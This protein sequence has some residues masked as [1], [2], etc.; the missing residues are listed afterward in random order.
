MFSGKIKKTLI[1]VGLI[2]ISGFWIYKLTDYI[3]NKLKFFQYKIS[4]KKFI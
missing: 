1:F 3:F 4:L 2:G